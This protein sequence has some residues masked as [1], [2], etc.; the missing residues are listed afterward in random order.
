M[1]HP[2]AAHAGHAPPAEANA[3]KLALAALGVVFGDIGTSPLYTLHECVSAPHGVPPTPENILGVLSLILWS[4]TMVVTVKYLA[5][6]MRA[7]NHGEGGIFALLALVPARLRTAPGGRIGWAA[8]LVI[9]GAALLYG[10]GM[11]TPAISVLSAIEGLQVATP[12]LKPAVLPITCVVIFGLFAIQHR[13][14]E[15]VGKLF[16][17]VMVVWFVTLAL[18]G[19]LHIQDNPSILRA[20]NPQH[21]VTF[22]SVHR[23]HGFIVLGS[24]VL[25]VT[26][27]EALYADMGHFGRWPIRLAWWV[28][29]MPA[30]ALNY[31]GQGA[32]L[33]KDP[34]AAHNPFFAMVPTGPWTYAL[35]ALSAAAT[36]IAS[37]ALI[38]GA[39]S[40]T[41]QAVQ[42]DFFPRATV[43][44]TSREIQ[45]QIYLP[46]INWGLA[47]CCIALVLTFQ[48]S[49]R[50]AAAYG[51]AVTGTMTVTSIIFFEVTRTTWKWPLWKSVPLLL[52]FLSFD[53]PFLVANLFKFP[54]GGF[55][56][57]LVGVCLFVMMFVWRKGRTI[58][59][60]HISAS[61]P[62]I[63]DFMAVQ[64]RQLV[65]RAPCTGVF[66]AAELDR[67]PTALLSLAEHLRVLP[68]TVVILHVVI[69]RS[70]HAGENTLAL[71]AFGDGVYRLQVDRGF[72]DVPDV[73]RALAA[74]V[75]RFQLPLDRTDITYYV[76]RKTFLA[77]NAGRMGRWSEALFAFL[78]RNA[79]PIS[80]HFCIPP[81]QVVEIGS[82]IDL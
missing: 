79:K 10:D 19:A 51:I 28:M 49:S 82:Q 36:V 57:L 6:I 63:R 11:I 13:G 53:I 3:G 47:I 43:K 40:L 26:G 8:V 16:A 17:P 67:V 58:Y 69:I 56:P 14:T 5:F 70:P 37:Q 38:S 75:K 80:D 21:A 24:V 73:P 74:A 27:G 41:N 33:L 4:L 25:A 22:F 12:A 61:L 34:G 59:A 35:V 32:L 77:T 72:M 20:V 68:R 62:L 50:L 39:F 2:T 52:L 23:R 29:V 71:D 81:G 76:G 44:H 15:R 78:A 45:G 1:V 60:D 31:V 18:L 46:E 65:A 64:C 7:D 9:A 54:D 48:Q 30:L 66:I 55:V 42:L